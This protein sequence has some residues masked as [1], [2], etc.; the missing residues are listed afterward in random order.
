M[1]LSLLTHTVYQFYIYESHQLHLIISSGTLVCS[2]NGTGSSSVSSFALVA[3][4]DCVD[5]A[6]QTDISFQ[7]IMTLGRSKGHH[8]HPHNHHGRGDSSSPPPPPPSP[9]LPHLAGPY[10]I[11]EFCVFEYNDPNDYFDVS[12]HE[13]DRQ[14]DLEYEEVELYK[15]SQQEKLGLTVCYRTD[16]EEDLGI[17]V[18]EVNPNSIASKNGRIREGDRI[19]QNENPADPGEDIELMMEEGVFH[20]TPQASSCSLNSSHLSGYYRLRWGA[21]GGL[22]CPGGGEEG[23]GEVAVVDVEV[24]EEE[25]E[26]DGERG[27]KEDGDTPVPLPPLLSLAPLL[28]NS[29]ELDSGVGRTDDSTRYEE[30]SE[31]DPLGDQTSACNTNTTNTPGSTRK[32]RPGPSPR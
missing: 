32:F 22:T 1:I 6:T 31:Q 13:V 18:G 5:N 11:N 26:E 19:L 21:G 27:E 23:G 8:H 4:P 14:D 20:P 12:N 17:Y 25:D 28:S 7:N 29:Q 10:G 30:L 3:I 2:G 15:S 24:E 16:D 9:P